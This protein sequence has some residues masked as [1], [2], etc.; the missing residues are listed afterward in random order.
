MSIR[1]DRSELKQKAL[2]NAGR[3]AERLRRHEQD[4]AQKMP[5]ELQ[6][7]EALRTAAAAA[8]RV[9]R[10]L[11]ASGSPGASSPPDP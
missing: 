4:L 10:L 2:E 1:T 6:G 9:A 3:I 8:E 7:G 11:E 5:D